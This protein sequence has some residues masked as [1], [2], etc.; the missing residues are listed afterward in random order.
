MLILVFKTTF[1]ARKHSFV[2]MYK[3]IKNHSDICYTKTYCKLKLLLMLQLFK[4]I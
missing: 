4:C 2:N 3:A 1:P